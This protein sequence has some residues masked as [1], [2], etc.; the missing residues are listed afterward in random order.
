MQHRI[1]KALIRNHDLTC[2]P[3]TPR[4]RLSPI[5]VPAH[6]RSRSVSSSCST[7]ARLSGSGSE[8]GHLSSAVYSSISRTVSSGSRV[9][10]CSTY[11]EAEH[12]HAGPAVTR[13]MTWPNLHCI[14][15][16][17]ATRRNGD[18]VVL[19]QACLRLWSTTALSVYC[20]HVGTK[21]CCTGPSLHSMKASILKPCQAGTA[22][23]RMRRARSAC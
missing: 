8:R 23:C 2:P 4:A 20:T 22:G 10:D 15:P 13:R 5:S 6:S 12:Q 3:E 16:S 9:S 1:C 18:N 17:C 14:L 21:A 7:R 11:P 19:Q